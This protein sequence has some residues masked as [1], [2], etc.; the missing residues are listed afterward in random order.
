MMKALRFLRTLGVSVALFSMLIVF[1]LT[2]SAQ[3]MGKKA[4][5]SVVSDWSHS[6]LL[7]PDSKDYAVTA[8]VQRDGRWKH[9]WYIRHPEAWWPDYHP[10]YRRDLKASTRDWSTTL[11]AAA[12]EPQYD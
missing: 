2:T 10:K 7:Y 5:L 6:H 11:G 12:Y 1:S 9:S 4:R 8:R 3:T